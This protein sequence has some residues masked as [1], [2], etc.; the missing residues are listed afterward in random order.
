MNA[1]PYWLQY[2]SE[3]VTLH[4][5]ATSNWLVD[6]AELFKDEHVR[7]AV[8]DLWWYSV[9]M[10]PKHDRDGC[11]FDLEEPRIYGIPTGGTPWAAAFAERYPGAILLNEYKDMRHKRQPTFLIDDVATTGSSFD[12]FPYDEPRLVVVR[13]LSKYPA[14]NVRSRWMDVFLPIDMPDDPT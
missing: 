1:A 11:E 3:P 5:G 9:W 10:Y 7:K 6:G 13:R 2:H 14:V 12:E 8:M 4:S